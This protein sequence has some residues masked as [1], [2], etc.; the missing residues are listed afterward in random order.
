MLD[1]L[2]LEL[3]DSELP[4]VGP[5]EEQSAPLDADP[6]VASCQAFCHSNEDNNQDR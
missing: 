3:H 1:S 5:L 2:R 4:T 6:K